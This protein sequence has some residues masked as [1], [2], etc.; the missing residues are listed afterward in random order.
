MVKGVS[1]YLF[2]VELVGFDIGVTDDGFKIMEINGLPGCMGCQWSRNLTDNGR[3][4]EYVR[5]K[6]AR[7][8]AL[9]EDE[10]LKR[11]GLH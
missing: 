3:F 1:C 11:R 7:I 6:L 10:R 5:A 8:D 4:V 2:G 9:P